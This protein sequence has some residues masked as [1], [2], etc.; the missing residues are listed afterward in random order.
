MRILR[1]RDFL[2]QLM[3]GA[4]FGSLPSTKESYAVPTSQDAQIS[5]APQ[6]EI[7]AVKSSLYGPQGI[8]IDEVD[9]LYIADTLHK[10]VRRVDGRTHLISTVAGNGI[11]ASTGDNGPAK[12]SSLRYPVNVRL[13]LAGDLYISDYIADRIRKVDMRTRVITTVAG[14]DLPT[15]DEPRKEG[16]SAVRRSLDRPTDVAFDQ[17]GNLYLTESSR[18]LRIDPNTKAMTTLAGTK[19][20]RGFS[21]DFGLA[22]SAKLKFPSALTIDSFGNIFISDRDNYRLRRID[23]K[24]HIISTIYEARPPSQS[25]YG[26]QAGSYLGALALDNGETLYFVESNLVKAINLQTGTVLTYAGSE[27][28]QRSIAD[29]I[30]ATEGRFG[31]V[32]GIALGRKQDLYVSDFQANKIWKIDQRTRTVQTV[33][34]NGLPRHPRPVIL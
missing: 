6:D 2:R 16:D 23:G 33:A 22:A 20:S 26:I 12:R 25:P 21:G 15:W 28:T 29:G 8:C 34:G 27:S 24:T 14:R 11:D 10:R 31:E 1:R 7:E 5:S 30:V 9:N 13:D 19:D 18:L 17:H 32:A 3:I 4:G